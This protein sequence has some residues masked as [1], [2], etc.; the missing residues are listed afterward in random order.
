MGL[1]RLDEWVGKYGHALSI[2]KGQELLPEAPEEDD[3]WHSAPGTSHISRYR[4]INN[5][6]PNA[7]E[8]RFQIH[9]VFKNAD[10]SESRGYLYFFPSAQAANGIFRRLR[11]SAHP[12]GSVLYP[13]VIQGKKIPYRPASA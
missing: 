1:S 8:T 3:T 7:G 10:G 6:N 13:D 5:P 11:S 9:V 2:P 4:Y 12:Y